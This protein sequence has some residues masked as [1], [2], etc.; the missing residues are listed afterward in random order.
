M[1]KRGFI[2]FVFALSLIFSLSLC[3]FAEGR[4]VDNANLFSDDEIA[5]IEEKIESFRNNY[6]YELYVLTA[7]DE[8]VSL[9][10]RADDFLF[11]EGYGY[12][13]SGALYLIDMYFRNDYISTAGE[14]IYVLSDSRREEIFDDTMYYLR[15]GDYAGA[16][17]SFIE[18]TEIMAERGISGNQYLY[19]EE[20]GKTYEHYS[21]SEYSE[22]NTLDFKDILIAV[23]LA[24]AGFLIPLFSIKSKYNLKGRTYNYDYVSNSYVSLRVKKDTYLRTS[25]VRIPKSNDN[26][27]SGGGSGTHTSS[28]G[29]TFG[30]SGGRGF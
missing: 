1:V 16:A 21:G 8:Y 5:A 12:G 2:L 17:L 26:D 28:G 29:G 3:S 30:G 9:R 7:D 11:D 23:A 6:G 18:D 14:M 10:D 19:N 15:N 25:V 13:E 22:K 27:S 4:V 20:T 24:V